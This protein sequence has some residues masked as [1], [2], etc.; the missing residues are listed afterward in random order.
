MQTIARGPRKIYADAVPRLLLIDDDPQLLLATE[1]ALKADG[2]EV[3]ALSSGSDAEHSAALARVDLI[4]CDINLPGV[5]GFSLV[6]RWR[7]RG[8]TLPILLLTSRDSEIDEAL[9]LELGA[10]DYVSKPVAMR[11]LCARVTALLRRESQRR[12]V[13]L[14]A[15]KIVG[16][17]SI[18]SERCEVRYQ[19]TLISCTLSEFRLIEALIDRVDIVLSRAKLLERVRGEES[20]VDDRLIDTYIRRLRR[21]FEAVDPAFVAIETVTG[22]GYRWRAP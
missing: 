13:A 3:I 22:F 5:D 19:N 8:I 16:S 2:H 18:D 6:K 4:L 15:A 21:K 7:A 20:V 9:G 1:L 11:V 10:D 12:T 17:L 14:P